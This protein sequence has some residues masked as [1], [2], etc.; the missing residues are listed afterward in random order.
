MMHI[1]F[2]TKFACPLMEIKGNN[3]S[4]TV[5]QTLYDINILKLLNKNYVVRDTNDKN[6]EY[7]INICHPIV[8]NSEAM[9]DGYS[10]VCRKNIS[11][12]DIRRRYL[13]YKI[14]KCTFIRK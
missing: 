8:F 7:I 4:L 12:P 6:I 9:C 1:N 10:S 14:Y 2:Y 11:E 13:I 3:C 5:D